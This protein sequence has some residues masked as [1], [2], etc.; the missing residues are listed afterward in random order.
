M[1]KNTVNKAL[2]DLRRHVS[3]S[4][5]DLLK[6]RQST[7]RPRHHTADSCNRRDDSNHFGDYPNNT[8]SGSW[9]SG[10]FFHFDF[11]THSTADKEK[12]TSKNTR[13]PEQK[14]SK[15]GFMML[16]ALIVIMTGLMS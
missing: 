5:D 10:N 6:K 15:M 1:T 16:I 14:G 3:S 7:S 2:Y 13:E 4:Y 8:Y 11:S 9:F 12:K